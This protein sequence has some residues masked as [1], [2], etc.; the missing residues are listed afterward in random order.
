MQ[1]LEDGHTF[2]DL[3]PNLPAPNAMTVCAITSKL[4]QMESNGDQW[5][6]EQYFSQKMVVEHV[7]FIQLDKCEMAKWS[8]TG[9]SLQYQFLINQTSQD[10]NHNNHQ[11]E[12]NCLDVPTNSQN[13]DVKRNEGKWRRINSLNT[14]LKMVKDIEYVEIYHTP[15]QGLK[16]ILHSSLLLG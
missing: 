1:S 8:T 5:S 15:L 9:F 12:D 16:N 2:I 11:L 6:K 14:V 7:A 4:L 3:F 13:S 10:E